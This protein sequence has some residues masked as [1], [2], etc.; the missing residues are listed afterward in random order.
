MLQY[1]L[2]KGMQVFRFL[3]QKLWLTDRIQFNK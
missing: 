3:S 1:N 2:G